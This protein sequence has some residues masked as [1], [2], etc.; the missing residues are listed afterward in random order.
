M[1]TLSKSGYIFM[2]SH[3]QR[4]VMWGIEYMSKLLPEQRMSKNG[5]IIV[6]AEFFLCHEEKV[7]FWQ[8]SPRNWH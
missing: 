4:Y 7:S 5:V 2:F 3:V 6:C 1:Q 8:L